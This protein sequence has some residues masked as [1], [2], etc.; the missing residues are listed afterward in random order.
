[1]KLDKF[2]F[3]CLKNGHQW[4]I[5]KDTKC[6]TFAVCNHCGRK[7]KKIKQ[8][9]Q[10][11]EWVSSEDCKNIRKC[12]KCDYKEEK[13]IPCTSFEEFEE[14]TGGGL[15]IGGRICTKCGNQTELYCSGN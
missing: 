1:M 8:K 4:I 9:H 12:K 14:C 13:T 3:Y 6:V 10:M 5:L 15:I 2:I 11:S 7:K